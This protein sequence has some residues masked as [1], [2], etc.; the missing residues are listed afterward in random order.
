MY[1][2]KVCE[3]NS[4]SRTARLSE[5]FIHRIGRRDN[6]RHTFRSVQ[7]S[8]V[9]KA[10]KSNPWSFIKGQI[11]KTGN[12]L[13]DDSAGTVSKEVKRRKVFSN[14]FFLRLFKKNIFADRVLNCS[15]QSEKVRNTYAQSFKEKMGQLCGKHLCTLGEDEVI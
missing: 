9:K 5:Y 15:Q 8:Q 13:I 4:W 6:S 2:P 7:W 3:I 12:Q 1:S 10:D 11:S 14:T